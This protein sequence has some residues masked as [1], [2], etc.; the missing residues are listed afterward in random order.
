MAMAA[1]TKL[2]QPV[3]PPPLLLLLLPLPP[4]LPPQPS[5]TQARLQRL[6]TTT[7]M[8]AA[9]TRRL[10]WRL[11]QR[12]HAKY[13]KAGA[14]PNLHQIRFQWLLLGELLLKMH[15]HQAF[16]VD[17]QLSKSRRCERQQ[18]TQREEASKTVYP[19]A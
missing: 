14:A 17:S 6:Q 5:Q 7:A 15:T 3:T 12:L 11:M 2:S 19:G 13:Q 18:G 16:S 4:S 9:A 1:P 8:F 10:S